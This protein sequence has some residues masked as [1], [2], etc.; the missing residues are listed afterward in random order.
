MTDLE[1]VELFH[2][3]FGAPVLD[4]A[5]LPSKD[6]V[7]LRI[8]LLQEELNE[9]SVAALGDSD[10][11]STADALADIAYILYGTV[12]EFGLGEHFEKLFDIVHESNMSKACDTEELAN[13]TIEYYQSTRGVGAYKELTDHGWIVKRSSDHKVLKSVAYTPAEPEIAKLLRD[14]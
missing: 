3:V 6:R 7:E 13:K 2:E 14:E 10:I 12:L 4:K 11:V 9:L 8:R 1:K 5:E